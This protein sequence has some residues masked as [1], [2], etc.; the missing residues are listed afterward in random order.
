MFSAKT[1]SVIHVF[2]RSIVDMWSSGVKLTCA[3]H[4]NIVNMCSSG[5]KLTCV[6]QG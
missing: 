6:H 4:E 5:V 3:H 2:I 1:D